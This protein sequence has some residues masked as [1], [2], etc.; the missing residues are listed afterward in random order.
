[1]EHHLTYRSEEIIVSV[2][3]MEEETQKEPR[4]RHPK[5]NRQCHCKTSNNAL[6]NIFLTISEEFIVSAF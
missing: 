4:Q 5:R 3:G 6:H 1:M 2:Q